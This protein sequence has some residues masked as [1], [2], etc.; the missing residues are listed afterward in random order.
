MSRDY[1]G[2]LNWDGS[3]AWAAVQETLVT[4]QPGHWRGRRTVTVVS[5]PGCEANWMVP[6]VGVDNP[7]RD[8]QSRP[9]PSTSR[10]WL[11]SPRKNRFEDARL[12]FAGQA[13]SVLAT[14]NSAAGPARRREMATSLRSIIFDCIVG[15]IEEQL[16]QTMAV[17][18]GWAFPGSPERVTRIPAGWA[19]MLASAKLSRTSS[20]NWKR[21]Q[22]QG[23]LAGV[24]LGEEGQSVH[25][26]GQAVNLINLAHEP[27]VLG[28]V[29]LLSSC[30]A[31]SNSPRSTV[32]GVLSSCE[33][34]R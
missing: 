33:A 16:A 5:W 11:A 3:W 10:L 32:S 34:W 21:F 20:S 19:R 1:F 23:D 22:V 28:A 31:V 4:L 13:R 9:Q 7:L 30:R 12:Q 8:A 26:L 6:A 27:G 15:Q 14:R 24:G 29:P 25:D 17:G 2:L 18:P